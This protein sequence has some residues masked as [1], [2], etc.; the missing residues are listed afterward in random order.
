VLEA[1]GYKVERKH[2]L[3]SREIVF[4]AI[5]RGDIN[6]VPEYLAT[7]LAFVAKSTALVQDPVAAR[8]QLQEAIKPKGLAIMDH[9]PAVDTNSFVVTKATAEKH[10]LKKMSDLAPVASQLTLGAPPTCPQR[11]FCLVGLEQT[12]GIKFKEFKP[13][14][15]GGP[16]TVAAIEGGQVDVG[17]L[18]STSAQISAKGF[19][20]LEDDKRLQAADNV[21]PMVRQDLLDRG[22]EDFKKLVNGVSAKLTT[23]K[24]TNLNKQVEIDK[25]EARDVARDWLR[26]EGLLK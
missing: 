20:L 8:G 10:K 14:D 24:L 6:F 19:V 16:L 25:K 15:T 13:L 17:L 21:A 7:V 22:G 4:P 23:D 9:A 18:F 5:E 3:G 12:Y 11:P 2:N 1:N 26:G